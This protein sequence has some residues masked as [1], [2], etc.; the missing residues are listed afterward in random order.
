MEAAR[1]QS[2]NHPG[3]TVH[4]IETEKYK[5]N[6]VII[7]LKAPLERETITMRALLP[8]VLQAGTENA[9]SATAFRSALDD[10]YGATFFADSAKKG[11]GHVLTFT[12]EVANETFLHG[13]SDLFDQALS[14]MSDVLFRPFLK[15]GVFPEKTVMQEKRSLQQRIRSIYD[16]KTRYAS[17]KLVEEMYKDDPYALSAGGILEDVEPITSAAL[18]DYYRKT[19]AGDTI[20]I[21]VIG[22]VKAAEAAAKIEAHFPFEKRTAFFQ[23]KSASTQ[24]TDVRVIHETQQINQ[25]KL[26]I[27]C[28]TSVTYADPQFAALQV[29]NGVFGGFAHSKL[30]MNVREKE[31]L[32]YYAASRLDSHKGFLMMLAGIDQKNYDKTVKIMNE[33]LDDM[34][35]GRITDLEMDQTKALLKNQL[36]ESSDT[37]RGMVELLYHNIAAGVDRPIETLIEEID[38]VT[39]EETAAAAKTVVVDTVYFLSGKEERE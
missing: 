29:F 7:K 18:Y 36:K 3:C 38:A 1:E 31:S 20:D 39:K 23:K 13:E 32:A 28:R 37:A 15:E 33:Q 5:T 2:F 25:G 9:P 11:D 30:F 27:G 35:E 17:M 14:V 19:L 26:T 8:H 4:V 16:D 10:L 6:T 34:K 12:I 22:D 21:F 24:V